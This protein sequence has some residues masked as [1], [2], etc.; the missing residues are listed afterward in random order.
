MISHKLKLIWFVVRKAGCTSILTALNEIHNT[1]F[2]IDDTGSK[3]GL[4]LGDYKELPYTKI[5][6]IRSHYDRL[7]SCYNDKVLKRG[8]YKS[9]LKQLTFESF[10][11]FVKDT[12]LNDPH[13]LPLEKLHKLPDDVE[14]VDLKD[15]DNWFK[16]KYNIELK[17]L[18]KCSIS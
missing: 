13:V 5:V 11:E 15:L 6:V 9:K 12:N 3:N 7:K 2:N 14:R 10:L 4:E 1:K 16:N 18:N 17:H 8:W